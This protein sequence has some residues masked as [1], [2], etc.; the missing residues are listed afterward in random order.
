MSSAQPSLVWFKRDL[1]VRDHAPLLEASQ[2]GELIAL[3][4]YEPEL[5]HNPEFDSSHLEFI[6]QSLSELATQLERVGGRLVTRV[7]EATAVLSRLQEETGFTRLYSHMETGNGLTFARD[8]RV[9]AWCRE[10]GIRWQ[11][12]AQHGI[13]R[14]SAPRP[15]WGVN[16]DSLMRSPTIEPPLG[17]KS[18]PL[19]TAGILSAKD[20]NLEPNRKEIQPGGSDAGYGLLE[21]FLGD[22]GREYQRAMSSPEAGWDACSR[23]SPHIAFGTVSLREAFQRNLERFDLYKQTDRTFARSLQSF[24]K[25]LHWHCHFM[26]KLE[27]QPDL[28]F[29]NLNRAF[30]GLREQNFDRERF[31]R[32]C[33]G[34]TGYPMIDACVR[35]LLHT[36]WINFRMRAMLVSFASHH[37]WLHWREVG[38]FLARHF[39]DFEPGIHWPQMQMQAAVTGTNTVRVYSAIKQAREQDPT[40]AF[41]RR[42]V[43]ELSAVPLPYLHQPETL[44]PLLTP[45]LDVCYPAPLVAEREVLRAARAEIYSL[46]RSPDA[47]L[48]RQRV[49]ERHSRAARHT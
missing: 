26:Q 5:I 24:H 23:L 11:E 4:L 34:V 29:R 1:R 25:R 38:V 16:W 7:G 35:C 33:R 21:S 41:I 8:R 19:E 48:E 44:P 13:M 45:M 30:D 10:R 9:K 49:L 43:P 42:W 14:G 31:E 47:R 15:V 2:H 39:L 3:Y 27:D 17:L 22:R 32:F 28:E 6:N 20:F 36:G 37:L 18:A 40:G 46:K 12:V